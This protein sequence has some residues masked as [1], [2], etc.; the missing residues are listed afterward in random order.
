MKK[1]KKIRYPS[2]TEMNLYFPVRDGNSPE[3]VIPAAILLAL[4]VALFTKFCVLDR[5]E[6]VR[7]AQR[8]L[9]TLQIRLSELD[10]QLETFEQTREDYYRYT[11]A[12]MT[13]GDAQ[14]VDRL[15]I[16]AM[17]ERNVP[18]YADYDTVT[19]SGNSVVLKLYSAALDNVAVLQRVLEK[20][21]LVSSVTVYNAD[22]NHY[23]EDGTPYVQAALLIRLAEEVAE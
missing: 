16:I 7:L 6:K 22:K 13:E 9:D 12:Y 4:I 1:N 18:A 5:L 19:I 17:L 20:D 10:E 23:A 2:K 11:R 21:E 14:T 15:E 8:E 3:I